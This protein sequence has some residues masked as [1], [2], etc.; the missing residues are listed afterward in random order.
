MTHSFMVSPEIAAVFLSG[1][2]Y[3]KDGNCFEFPHFTV[4]ALSDIFNIL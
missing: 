4:T 2:A 3:A 1:N